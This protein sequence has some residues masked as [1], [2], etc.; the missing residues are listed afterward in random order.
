M[1][2]FLPVVPLLV[3]FACFPAAAQTPPASAPP[4][5]PPVDPGSQAA[6]QA[7]QERIQALEKELA[8]AHAT[9]A[10]LKAEIAQLKAAGGVA[11]TP[12]APAAELTP[13]QAL[14]SVQHF[15]RF[16]R[17]AYLRDVAPLVGTDLRSES[18]RGGGQRTLEKWV[19]SMN[20]DWRKPVKWTVV[21]REIERRPDG[22]SARIQVVDGTTGESFGDVVTLPL[23][24]RQAKRLESFGRRPNQSGYWNLA[25]VFTPQLTVNMARLDPGVFD[26]PP[27]I[28][29]GVEFRYTLVAESLTPIAAAKQEKEPASR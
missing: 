10:T 4:A 16:S 3:A 13:D 12:P 21:V 14:L 15:T 11:P 8:E 6:Q 25:A 5:T 29:P 26:T 2:R 20:R 24:E 9:I 18:G 17:E 27:Y 7:A 22:A 1:P 23:D 19:G 28:G